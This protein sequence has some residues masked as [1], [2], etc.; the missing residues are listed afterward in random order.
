MG[1]LTEIEAGSPTTEL[2]GDS[3]LAGFYLNELLLRL[4]PR[5][6]QNDAVVNCYSS[7]LDRLTESR[8]VARALRI[9]ELA[10][11]E[12]LGL[13]IDLERDCRTGEAIQAERCY[14]FEH[15]GGLT[16]AGADVTRD[17]LSGRHLISLREHEL[18]D[19]ESLRAA[20]RLLGGI[21]Q[22][23]LGE[24][25]LRTRQVLRDIVARGYVR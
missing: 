18:D 16:L 2:T 12:A 4:V 21:L 14:V 5:G 10:L 24:R 19:V 9:F 7:C 13:G 8:R 25:P 3:L 17:A 1:R 23:Q 11:L 22:N 6:D 15:E 20:K